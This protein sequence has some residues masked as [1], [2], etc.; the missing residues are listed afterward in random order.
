[1]ATPARLGRH[2]LRDLVTSSA[3]H[4]DQAPAVTNSPAASG[5]TRPSSRRRSCAGSGGCCGRVPFM[6]PSQCWSRHS[7]PAWGQASTAFLGKVIDMHGE[8][9]GSVY[10]EVTLG[11]SDL[12]PVS[13]LAEDRAGVLECCLDCKHGHHCPHLHLTHTGSGTGP[14]RGIGPHRRPRHPRRS[15]CQAPRPG[16]TPQQGQVGPEAHAA[17]I[18]PARASWQTPAACL[19]VGPATFGAW[20]AVG[21]LGCGRRAKRLRGSLA[22][23]LGHAGWPIPVA[24]SGMATAARL[25]VPEDLEGVRD[26]AARESSDGALPDAGSAMVRSCSR[27]HSGGDQEPSA[28]AGGCR[29]APSP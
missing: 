3:A 11:R 26:P 14:G 13:P 9:N 17:R 15:Q 16:R 10:Q 21:H 5:A 27:R 12:A 23:R 7:R 6:P 29:R 25:A 20:E 2:G 4:A 28:I 18:P 22:D 1:V 24:P 8:Q 19:T